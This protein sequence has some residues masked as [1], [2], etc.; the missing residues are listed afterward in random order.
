[1]SKGFSLI[2]LLVVVAIIGILAAIGTVGYSRYITWSQDKAQ[3]ANLEE[4]IH[5][6]YVTLFGFKTNTL[7]VNDPIY[8]ACNTNISD[9]LN[10]APL[11]PSLFSGSS[12]D[13]IATIGQ[14]MKSPY[15]PSVT[16]A[17][18]GVYFMSFIS[19]PS[20]SMDFCSSNQF[21]YSWNP[22]NPGSFQL[23]NQWFD[24]DYNPIPSAGPWVDSEGNLIPADTKPLPPGSMPDPSTYPPNEWGGPSS[25]PY[26]TDLK[27]NA[28]QSTASI[29]YYDY[30]LTDSTQFNYS[31]LLYPPT[32]GCRIILFEAC[33]S[34]G[35]AE[36]QMLIIN[37]N[38]CYD[39]SSTLITGGVN[40]VAQWVLNNP[41]SG[42]PWTGSQKITTLELY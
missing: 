39:W 28:V 25:Y 16:G 14:N 22:P 40:A 21:L 36:S 32:A 26:L 3:I 27:G 4:L 13:C 37:P 23:Q 15:N 11:A 29:Y 12:N 18:G 17:P 30:Q 5:G 20:S 35:K 41:F 10:G 24:S 19:G 42:A 38:S 33:L 2:E 7:S 6:V 1:M 31:N 34:G 9:I 8:N